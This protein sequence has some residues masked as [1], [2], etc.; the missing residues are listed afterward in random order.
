MILSES[1][2]VGL[3]GCLLSLAFGVYY[4]WLATRLV[5][6]APMFGIIAPPLDLPW[7]RLLPGYAL[8]L[9]IALAAGAIPAVLIG[10]QDIARL[11]SANKD[12]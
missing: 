10:R 1:R 8:A 7:L 6:L 3:C 9:L 5:D 11:L 2:P 12:A 4:A